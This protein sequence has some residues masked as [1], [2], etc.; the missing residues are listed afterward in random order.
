MYIKRSLL[1]AG[2]I[3]TSCLAQA[4]GKMFVSASA[5]L[6]ND[7]TEIS[8]NVDLEPGTTNKA[9]TYG[10]ETNSGFVTAGISY[11]TPES[12]GFGLKIG[13]IAPAEDS[14]FGGGY[15]TIK[16]KVSPTVEV[17]AIYE[18]GSGAKVE[19]GGRMTFSR[20]TLGTTTTGYYFNGATARTSE[21][22][23][24]P[25]EV[26]MTVSVPLGG[27]EQANIFVGGHYG[28]K[29]DLTQLTTALA[30]HALVIPVASDLGDQ[31]KSGKVARFGFEAGFSFGFDA[32]D[33]FGG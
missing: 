3:A 25:I 12:I 7:T 28:I 24:K 17:D 14:T 11:S 30:S 10:S 16:Q 22:E 5:G 29:K 21:Q 33:T 19:L 8:G 23:P 4:D 6:R 9:T 32:S 27:M 1:L 13:A 2:L 26:V 31:I 20:F 15:L 18:T